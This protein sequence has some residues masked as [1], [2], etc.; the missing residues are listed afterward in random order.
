M[1]A[2]VAQD[3]TLFD[4]T[5]ADNLR[6]GQPDATDE[7]M[8]VAARSANAHDFICALPQGYE[9]PIGERGGA[10]NASVSP[11]PAHCCA[12]PRS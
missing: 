11:L 9:T 10:D 4:G 7:E 5:I 3:T 6:L 12:M 8:I 2:I 1:I